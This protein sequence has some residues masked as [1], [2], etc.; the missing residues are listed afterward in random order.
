MGTERTTAAANEKP[1]T[2]VKPTITMCTT[3]VVDN[4]LHVL[5]ASV[6]VIECFVLGDPTP[7]LKPICTAC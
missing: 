3:R 4:F 7:Q 2:I 5:M 6:Q 1:L